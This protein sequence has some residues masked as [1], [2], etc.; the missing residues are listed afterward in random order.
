MNFTSQICCLFCCSGLNV[1]LWDSLT[2]VLL[3]SCELS[4]DLWCC[5]ISYCQPK[6]SLQTSWT[7]NTSPNPSRPDVINNSWQAFGSWWVEICL[8]R[9]YYLASADP[10]VFL[11]LIQRS[12]STESECEIWSWPGEQTSW[13]LWIFWVFLLMSKAIFC[14]LH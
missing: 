7:C 5:L 3:V 9:W 14:H 1:R 13:F 10:D 11:M 2:T 6:K 12:L 8:P 4:W